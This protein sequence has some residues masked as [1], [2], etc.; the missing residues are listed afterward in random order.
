MSRHWKR[1]R[2]DKGFQHS[3]SPL[4]QHL[5]H[6][7][8]LGPLVER[9]LRVALR[10]HDPI[11]KRVLVA[12][13]C[14]GVTL[15]C[16]LMLNLPG[17]GTAGFGRVLHGLLFWIGLYLAVVETPKL[18]AGV[19]AKE[20]R[21]QT[22]GLLF[23]T[24]LR[25]G[26]VFVGKLFSSATI[27]FFNLL[28]LVPFLALPFLAGSVSLP[29]FAATAACLPVLLLFTLSLAILGSVLCKDDG[30]AL[31]TAIGLGLLL[32][33]PVPVVYLL[34]KSL[35]TS[36]M[37]PH[38]LLL[39][40][41]FGPYLVRQHFG[42]GSAA[43]FWLNCA[44]TLLWSGL[45]LALA[46]VVLSRTWQE[47]FE[48]GAM[49]G[50][51]ARLE[52]WIHGPAARRRAWAARW[53]DQ[54]PFVWLAGHDRQPVLVA[55]AVV[56]G[57][58]LIWLAGWWAWPHRWPSVP[59]F[60]VTAFSLIVVVEWLADYATAKRVG[61]DRRSGA[62]ELLLTTPLFVAE[63]VEGQGLATELQFRPLRRTLLGVNCALMTAGFLIRSWNL[64]AVISYCLIWTAAFGPCWR[65]RLRLGQILWMGLNSGRRI[66]PGG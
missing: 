50:L 6:P 12:L 1:S 39:S 11:R 23:L 24:G 32:C 41:A 57:I 13:A 52:Q 60:F 54:N 49:E 25:A 45:A 35:G 19:F 4:L 9:E 31:F 10:K 29:V 8:N 40:P 2:L 65:R 15:V 46:A 27:A 48:P 17:L 44:V 5:V 51:R 3:N 30:A 33:A 34:N 47:P 63:I 53:L 21:D 14:T 16:F 22:L 64:K 59:N 36:P 26:E 43:E 42:T 28:A 37:S 20:R 58:A 66:Q 55:W 7:L 62:L 56:A 18:T 38:W 61:E